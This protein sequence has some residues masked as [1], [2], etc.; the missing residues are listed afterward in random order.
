MPK[1][2]SGDDVTIKPDNLVVRP[3]TTVQARHRNN[4]K[5]QK[6]RDKGKKIK[7][8]KEDK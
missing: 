8:K 7:V 3:L 1:N 4:I 6:L 5:Q 2:K